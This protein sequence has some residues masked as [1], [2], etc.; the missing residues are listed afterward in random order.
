MIIQFSSRAANAVLS[1][2]FSPASVAVVGAGDDPAKLRGKLFKLAI[3]SGYAGPVY[4]VHPKAEMIQGRPAFASIA[5]IPG[6]AELVLIATPGA[7]VPAVIRDAI[8]AGAKAAV[9][10]SSGVDMA[11]LTDAIGDSGLRYMGPNTEGYFDVG[12]VAGTFAAVVQEALAMDGVAPRPGR[13][14]SI[15]S[16]SGGLGF[17]LFGRGLAENF[18]FHSIITTGNE[19]DLECLDFVEHLLDEGESGV[20]LMFIEGLKTPARFAAVAAKAADKGVPIVVM[21]VGRSEAGQR[22]AVSHTAH[23]TGADTAYD[24]VFERYGVI[25]V[26]DMEE[27][28][29]AAAAFARFPRGRV[30]RAAVVSTSGGAGAWAAD[31]LGAASI[32]VPELSVELQQSLQQFI[33]EFGSP[34]NPV[35]V[36]A[37]AVE[38]GGR[39]LVQVLEK[40]Q[41]SDEIDAIVVNMGLHVPGRIES[42]SDL[43]GPLYAD[44]TKPILF[45][46][47]ILP[48]ANNLAA[49]ARL[50]GQGFASFRG[51]ASALAA[52]DRHAVFLEGWKQR[53]PAAPVATA[54]MDNAPAGV[55]TEADTARLLNAYGVP[56]PPNALA[57]TREDAAAQAAAMGFPVVLKIQ[58]PDIAH[59][60]EAGGVALNVGAGEVEGI[61]DRIIASAKAYAPDARIEGVLIQKM[62][63]KGHEIV[64]GVTRDPDFGPLVMLGSGGIYL[65]VLKD[66]VFAPVPITPD[67]AKAMIARLKTAPILAGTRGQAAGDV[68]ALAALVSR[69][70]DLARAEGNIDQL[71]LNPVFVYPAGEGVVAVDALI[72]AGQPVAGGH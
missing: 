60:T 26:S 42:L 17:C 11:D 56:V 46:S 51:C 53:A 33:P 16:Q 28:L 65:E 68:D 39:P 48:H 6:G 3:D 54:I 40:L 25:R 45:H 5:E 7:T 15:V 23:L 61:F 52:L 58:S 69:V 49:L 67:D 63:P 66:V 38:A 13:K 41:H 22:A 59:K 19:G 8:A 72:V 32:D 2:F 37:Q 35:D 44:A 50:G 14:V 1:S 47:H 20:I 10:L 34:A 12:G 9:I 24:A 27:M 36:T 62:M 4:P 70:A 21:K 29:A 18:D 57:S 64:I 71:D 30:K 43:L 55:L 31:L